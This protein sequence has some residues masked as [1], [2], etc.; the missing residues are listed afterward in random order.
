MAR[1]EREEDRCDLCGRE[2]E[3]ILFS[4]EDHIMFKEKKGFIFQ[5][6]EVF[7]CED[8][9]SEGFGKLGGD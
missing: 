8:C 6:K 9:L 4:G 7:V 3:G 1:I 5:R 2:D